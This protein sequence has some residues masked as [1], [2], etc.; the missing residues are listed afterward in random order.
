LFPETEL[1]HA[2]AQ[3]IAHLTSDQMLAEQK[4]RPRLVMV[5]HNDRIG[6]R[7]EIVDPRP[8][9]EEPAQAAARLVARLEQFPE[10][11]EAR[12]ELAKIYADHY[13]RMDLASDQI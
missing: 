5:Q 10:D 3:R 2:A 11:A 4:E 9:S 7:G 13:H 6:L 12:E 8:P 1:A